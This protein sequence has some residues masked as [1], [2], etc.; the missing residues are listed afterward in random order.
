MK[1]QPPNDI[2]IDLASVCASKPIPMVPAWAYQSGIQT[3]LEAE[4]SQGLLAPWRPADP[5]CRL[6]AGSTGSR[7]VP[8]GPVRV[9]IYPKSMGLGS[10]HTVG[11]LAVQEDRGKG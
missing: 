9:P 4:I 5:F 8:E 10:D 3:S 7:T 11:P 6:E 1:K 2:G